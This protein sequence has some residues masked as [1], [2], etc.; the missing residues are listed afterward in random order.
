M[1]LYGILIV[2][3]FAT[4]HPACRSAAYAWILEA[5]EGAWSSEQHVQERYRTA[6]VGKNGR[7]VFDLL[8]GIYMLATRV[9][10]DKGILVVERAWV[11]GQPAKAAARASKK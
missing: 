2:Q 5:K 3:R 7:V 4:A 1:H 6:Q 10:Y 9:M 11:D 8:T